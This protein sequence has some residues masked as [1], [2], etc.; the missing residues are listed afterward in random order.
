MQNLEKFVA[1]NAKTENFK[2]K[3]LSTSGKIIGERCPFWGGNRV[4]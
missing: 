3:K 4:I 2:I 1:Y